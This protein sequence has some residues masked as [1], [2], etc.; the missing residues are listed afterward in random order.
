[1]RIFHTPIYDGYI[2]GYSSTVALTT[3]H[4]VWC[5]PMGAVDVFHISGYAS[6]ASGTNPTLTIKEESSND[7]W[8]WDTYVSGTIVS[9]VSLSTSAETV[10]Q[11]KSPAPHTTRLWPF[12]RLQIILGGTTP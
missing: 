11:G 1:M 8:N 2:S 10:F 12:R 5:N 3:T 9:T 7:G 4:L 6:A